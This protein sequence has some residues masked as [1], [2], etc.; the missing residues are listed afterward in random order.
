[1]PHKIQLQAIKTARDLH[2]QYNLK[3]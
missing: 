3:L 2:T 1:M